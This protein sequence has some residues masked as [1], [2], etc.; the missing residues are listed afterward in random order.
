MALLVSFDVAFP[1]VI[2]SRTTTGDFERTNT[3]TH[4]AGEISQN[5]ANFFEWFVLMTNHNPP[6]PVANPSANVAMISLSSC[7]ML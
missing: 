3:D 1:F 6:L 5:F 2:S 7:V 4:S